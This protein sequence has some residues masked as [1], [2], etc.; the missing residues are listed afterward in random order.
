M[1]TAI[2][3]SLFHRRTGLINMSHNALDSV[4]EIY[5]TA[6]NSKNP[7]TIYM[8]AKFVMTQAALFLEGDLYLRAAEKQLE[9]LELLYREQ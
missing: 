7:D 4:D 5:L 6:K 8:A 1:E 9:A 3:K 2:N